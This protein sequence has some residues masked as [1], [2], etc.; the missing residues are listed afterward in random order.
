LPT[1]ASRYIVFL[2]RTSGRLDAEDHMATE[3]ELRIG[4]AE[5]EAAATH[6]R[7]NY[8]Q[9]R[10]TLDE[11][12]QRLDAVFGATTRGQLDA[13]IA[14]LPR[15]APT[16]D[17]LPVTSPAGGRERAREDY[18]SGRRVRLGF[19]PVVIAALATWLLIVEMHLRVFPWPGKL[20]IFLAIL[21]VVRGVVKRVLGLG[22]GG[23]GYKCGPRGR[24][25]PRGG[26]RRSARRSSWDI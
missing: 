14:D 25:G 3:S 8:A 5:R 22:G 11:F 20:A 1:A 15:S 26:R 19:F 24:R 2:A 13:L 10:L 18:R 16:A 9:G 23:L 17:P 4:H 7:E 21:A 12:N 6:L